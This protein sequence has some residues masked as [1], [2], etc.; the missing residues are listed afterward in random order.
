[1]KEPGC[2]IEVN[3]QGEKVCKRPTGDKDREMGLAWLGLGW[4][5]S[6]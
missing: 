4:I 5:L 2:E 6:Y 1:M 3:P